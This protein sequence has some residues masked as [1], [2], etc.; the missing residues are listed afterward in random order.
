MTSLSQVSTGLSLVSNE[1]HK[2]LRGIHHSSLGSTGERRMLHSFDQAVGVHDFSN[3]EVY[4]T[5]VLARAEGERSSIIKAVLFA[6]K[7]KRSSTHRAEVRHNRKI[8]QWP[9]SNHRQLLTTNSALSSPEVSTS[10]HH[11]NIPSPVFILFL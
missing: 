4:V 1:S 5:A 10:L 7:E 2:S 8:L 3:L 9:G 11:C 6:T